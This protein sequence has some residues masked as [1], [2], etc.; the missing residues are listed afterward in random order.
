MLPTLICPQMLQGRKAPQPTVYALLTHSET[1]TGV[2]NIYVGNRS[3]FVTIFI[4]FY[5]YHD[6]YNDIYIYIIDIYHSKID[7]RA[8]LLILS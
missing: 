4:R 8:L 2:R 5:I 3:M 6:T 1:G 7:F